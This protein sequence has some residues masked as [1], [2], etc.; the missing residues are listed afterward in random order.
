MIKDLILKNRSYRRFHQEEQISL[1]TL[2][3]LVELA[4]LSASASNFQ[5]LKYFLSCDRKKNE[6]IFKCLSWA[7]YFKDWPGPKEGERPSGYILIL[8]D[9]NISKNFDHDCGIAAQSILLGATEKE[10]GGCM[11]ASIQ[12][13]KL[14]NSLNIPERYQIL[15]AIALGKPKE[16]VVIEK[17]NADGDIKY[18]RDNKDIHHVPKRPLNE[19]IIS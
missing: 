1:E 17:T 3:E 6:T 7:G 10:L 13:E 5:P 19:I 11:I 18:W 2:R 4:R 15:L 14:C 16:Q 8:G 12:N 9:T